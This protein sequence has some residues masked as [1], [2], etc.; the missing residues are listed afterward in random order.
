MLWPYAFE[1][2]Y[3]QAFQQLID[4]AAVQNVFQRMGAV[5]AATTPSDQGQ[6]SDRATDVASI[7]AAQLTNPPPVSCIYPT[8]GR[9]DE[10]GGQQKCQ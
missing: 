8:Y 9:I 1:E 10:I 2:A 3:E 7:W 6:G 4:S 5:A